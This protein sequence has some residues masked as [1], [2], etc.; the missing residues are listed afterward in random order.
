M[1]DDKGKVLEVRH[2]PTGCPGRCA[3]CRR[4]EPGPAGGLCWGCGRVLGLDLRSPRDATGPRGPVRR[5]PLWW[6]RSCSRGIPPKVGRRSLSQPLRPRPCLRPRG[7]PLDVSSSNRERIDCP[8]SFTRRRGL[9]C[10]CREPPPGDHGRGRCDKVL[11]P[12]RPTGSPLV[13]PP[14]SALPP[15]GVCD[16]ATWLILPVV[17]CLSQRLSHACPSTSL[18]TKRNC[19]WLIKSVMVPLIVTPYSDN[20]GNS[21]AN[22][23][24]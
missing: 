23:C 4:M 15:F 24:E 13:A 2:Y 6:R 1:G 18:R 7:S 9:P 22:T 3:G 11:C 8:F 19:E 12:S 21:R 14:A 5:R 10:L 16:A 20:C 17:I